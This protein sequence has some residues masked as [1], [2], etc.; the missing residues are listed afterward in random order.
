MMSKQQPW[1]LRSQRGSSHLPNLG[2][3]SAPSP[4]VMEPEELPTYQ[5]LRAANCNTISTSLN[6]FIFRQ[7]SL[8]H[9]TLHHAQFCNKIIKINSVYFLLISSKNPASGRQ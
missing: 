2:E 9:C 6:V 7:Y 5:S 8:A 1:S 3:A 4:R